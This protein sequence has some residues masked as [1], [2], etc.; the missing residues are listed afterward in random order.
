MKLSC[1]KW[2]GVHLSKGGSMKSSN[3]KSPKRQQ[4][5]IAMASQQPQDEDATR[6]DSKS[7]GNAGARG[8]RGQANSGAQAGNSTNQG[9]PPPPAGDLSDAPDAQGGGGAGSGSSRSK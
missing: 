7:P 1:L 9:E 2:S 3:P 4:A 6:P 5:R 8:S